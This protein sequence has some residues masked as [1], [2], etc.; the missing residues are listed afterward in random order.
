VI[1]LYFPLISNR[2]RN[3]MT[4]PHIIGHVKKGG[5]QD[6]I[7]K[8]DGRPPIVGVVD[9]RALTQ[10]TPEE[11]VSA[12]LDKQCPRCSS[13]AIDINADGGWCACGFSY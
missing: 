10:A 6:P 7:W 9:P 8:V 12:K 13:R 11:I 1:G 2:E 5:G 4:E 3:T